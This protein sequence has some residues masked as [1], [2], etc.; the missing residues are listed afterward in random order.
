MPGVEITLPPTM[1]RRHLQVV[2]KYFEKTERLKPSEWKLALAAFDGLSEA[3]VR[4]D[5]KPMTFAQF[6]HRFVDRQYADEFIAK[7]YHLSDLE[8]AA[9]QIQAHIATQMLTRLEQDQIYREEVERSEYLAAYCLY[10]WTSFAR[11]YRFELTIFRDLQASGIHFVAHDVRKRKE[12]FSPYDLVVLSQ[13]GEIKTTTYFLHTARTWSLDRD[14]YI[15]RLYH[16]RKRRYLFVVIMSGAAW[17]QINGP[18]RIGSLATAADFFPQPVA[19]QLERQH[20][21]VVSFELWKEKI[22]KRQHAEE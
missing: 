1:T 9:E 10:W 5:Q 8:M 4:I 21:V 17:E 13:L 11:G 15:T 18:L 14:F 3:I 19:F 7:I 2:L 12:R 16:P 20:F 6:Y 22:L